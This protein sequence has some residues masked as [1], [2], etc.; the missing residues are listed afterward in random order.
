L[1]L[2]N[3]ALRQQL[4]DFRQIRP[5]PALVN[6]DRAFWVLLRA[7]RSEWSGA[8]VI[9]IV[10]PETVVRWHRRGFWLYWDALSRK[11]RI[12]GRPRIDREIRKLTIQVAAENPTWRAPRIHGE[13][14][15]LGYEVAERTVSRCLLKRPPDQDKI[16]Q[17]KTFLENHRHAI[18][19]MDLFTIPLATFRVLY[20]PIA[21]WSSSIM[22]GAFCVTVTSVSI[23]RRCGSFSNCGRPFPLTPRHG[24]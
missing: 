3:V 13:L 7:I 20:A 24:I 14:L 2:E 16:R 1:A 5:R 4:A 6:A 10:T 23:P 22:G 12:P 19:A 8:Q 21:P 9:V 15:M 11:D 18:V 17:W